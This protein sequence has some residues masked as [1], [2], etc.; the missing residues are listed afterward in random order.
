MWTTDAVSR[1][2]QSIKWHKYK[3]GEGETTFHKKKV[4]LHPGILHCTA[5]LAETS[6]EAK[7]QNINGIDRWKAT[8]KSIYSQ[9]GL[10]HDAPAIWL[11]PLNAPSLMLS[12]CHR[13]FCFSHVL[14][15]N[16]KID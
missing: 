12:F 8:V 11:S 1:E 14:L 2:R 7:K 4:Y 13:L 15:F 9:A 3:C 16:M 6:C 5:S 10:W